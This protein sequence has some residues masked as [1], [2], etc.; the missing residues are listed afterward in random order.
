MS[1]GSTKV[2]IEAF[3][4]RCSWKLNNSNFNIFA[5]SG[6]TETFD[7]QECQGKFGSIRQ[8]RSHVKDEHGC[9]PDWVPG[10]KCL[11]YSEF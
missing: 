11:E 8:L 2:G 10:M 4:A 9:V 5:F 3:F 1:G 6:I 7:C